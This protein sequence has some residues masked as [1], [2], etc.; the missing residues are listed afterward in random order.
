[1]GDVSSRVDSV[2]H[3]AEQAIAGRSSFTL[4]IRHEHARVGKLQ[5]TVGEVVLFFRNE[6]APISIWIMSSEVQAGILV[7]FIQEEVGRGPR[8]SE[9][10][11][12]GRW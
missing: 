11:H 3:S 5:R 12:G 2:N 4:A 10:L 8:W 7:I 9:S 1:M 6:P